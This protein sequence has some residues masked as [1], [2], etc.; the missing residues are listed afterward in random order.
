MKIVIPFDDGSELGPFAVATLAD[1][2]REGFGDNILCVP[3]EPGVMTFETLGSDSVV[4]FAYP[5]R[6]TL[7][8]MLTQVQRQLTRQGIPFVGSPLR[9]RA[10]PVGDEFFVDQ[11]VSELDYVYP[12]NGFRCLSVAVLADPVATALPVVE[13]ECLDHDVKPSL[14]DFPVSEYAAADIPSRVTEAAQKIALNLHSLTGS[15]QLSR[16]DFYFVGEK[17]I[18]R[19]VFTNP[20][21][22]GSGSLFLRAAEL[23][24]LSFSEVT[25]ILVCRA[26][27]RHFERFRN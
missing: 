8:P 23:A 2:L 6:D 12:P 19:G 3:L 1:A 9:E 14:L 15:V 24:G 5:F 25:R 16:T 17:L 27:E 26:A 13:I 20:F 22:A 10:M 4:F 11:G 21:L 7:R 18:A